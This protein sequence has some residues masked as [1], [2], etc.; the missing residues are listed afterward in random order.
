MFVYKI[1]LPSKISF[2]KYHDGNFP[3]TILFK[4]TNCYSYDIGVAG[5]GATYFR[6][7]LH[8]ETWDSELETI[9][10]HRIDS[11]FLFHIEDLK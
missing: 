4:G 9:Q 6:N 1:Q 3:Y 8:I 7:L 2:S 11:K 5:F 10:W